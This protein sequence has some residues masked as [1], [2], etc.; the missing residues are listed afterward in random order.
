MTNITKS[1][2][3]LLCILAFILIHFNL[4]YS[5]ED[6]DILNIYW[7]YYF[8][9]KLE[10]KNK[11]NIDNTALQKDIKTVNDAMKIINDPSLSS[12]YDR[13]N[14]HRIMND[15]MN[16]IILVE[17]HTD[18][19]KDIETATTALIG[20][21]SYLTL[22]TGPNKRTTNGY[23]S[24]NKTINKLWSGLLIPQYSQGYDDIMLALQLVHKDYDDL[25]ISWALENYKLY[26]PFILMEASRRLSNK[27]V[28]QAVFWYLV[29][30]WKIRDEVKKCN[31]YASGDIPALWRD[32][33]LKFLAPKINE[34]NLESNHVIFLNNLIKILK[35]W[36]ELIPPDNQSWQRCINH[37][38]NNNNWLS[39]N[40]SLK[41]IAEDQC[42]K[43]TEKK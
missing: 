29:G 13:E 17:N 38:T 33:G 11:S 25:V 10:N 30:L 24:K 5:M 23:I 43:F 8:D 27:N 15:Y 2:S 21:K 41:K 1:L 32:F 3:F 6:D 35:N 42:R 28:N 20:I 9:L 31:I 34:L 26:S 40:H 7:K 14:I 39:I 4:S 37:K 18:I 22:S 16:F 12:N 19:A 36:D